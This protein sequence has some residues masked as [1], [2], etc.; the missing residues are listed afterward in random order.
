MTFLYSLT[1]L[2]FTLVIVTKYFTIKHM[3]R[4]TQRL[5]QV[6]NL[7]IH[8]EQRRKV[9]Q[10]QCEVAESEEK[11]IRAQ[12]KVMEAQL[13]DLTQELFEEDKRVSELEEQLTAAQR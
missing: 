12:G 6:E 2:L 3:D 5:V 4:L 11:S 9:A 10:K 8:N 1:I 13:E 7:C